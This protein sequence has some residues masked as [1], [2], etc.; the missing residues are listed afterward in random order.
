MQ[1]EIEKGQRYRIG[2]NDYKIIAIRINNVLSSEDFIT[3][4]CFEG[5]DHVFE[6]S[7]SRVIGNPEYQLIRE[8][9]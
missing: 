1:D 8:N 5:E 3:G 6:V 9:Y 2:S 7:A 4:I